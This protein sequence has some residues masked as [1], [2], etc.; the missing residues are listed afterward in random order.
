MSVLEEIEN[1]YRIKVENED[2]NFLKKLNNPLNKEK[3]KEL[4][5]EYRENL[6][7]ILEEYRENVSKILNKKDVQLFEREDSQKEKKEKSNTLSYF[8]IGRVD[9]NSSYKD[10]F[11]IK[12]N[13]FKFNFRIN[14]RDFFHKIIPTIFIIFFLRTKFR[15]INLYSEIRFYVVKFFKAVWLKIKNLWGIIKKLTLSGFNFIKKFFQN[16]IKKVFS[17][18]DKDSKEK[19]KKSSGEEE[20]SEKSE[21]S[22]DKKSGD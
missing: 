3:T 7:S 18:I 5:K 20:K 22:K 8:K 6:K 1:S 12:W 19:D 10:R 11:L 2:D 21:K 16:L 9:L 4:E 15:I 14:L 17:F 13:I